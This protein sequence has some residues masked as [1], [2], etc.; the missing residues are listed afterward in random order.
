MKEH[1]ATAN[2]GLKSTG[3]ST[4]SFSLRTLCL[5][6]CILAM[7]MG[8]LSIPYLQASIRTVIDEGKNSHSIP[9]VEPSAAGLERSAS[10]ELSDSE[11]ASHSQTFSRSNTSVI[12]ESSN[13]GAD[14]TIRIEGAALSDGSILDTIP[15][16]N[17]DGGK[18]RIHDKTSSI[19]SE[20]EEEE[21]DEEEEVVVVVGP[22]EE[23]TGAEDL[24]KNFHEDRTPKAADVIKEEQALM[25]V[26][27]A[28]EEDADDR[29]SIQQETK[30]DEEEAEGSD[31]RR[32]ETVAE[33]ARAGEAGDHERISTTPRTDVIAD[34][35]IDSSESDLDRKGSSTETSRDSETDSALRQKTSDDDDSLQL[36]DRARANSSEL[37]SSRK[38]IAGLMMLAEVA[39]SVHEKMEGSRDYYARFCSCSC[40]LAMTEL[41]SCIARSL[42]HSL[43]ALP[44]TCDIFT[45]RWIPDPIGPL[46][47]HNSC[48]VLS[49]PQN[50]QANGR[51]DKL[52]E[53]YRWQPRDCDIPR[54]DP[55]AFL[56]V[57]KGKTLAFI[58]DSVARNQFESLMCVLFQ[59]A[60]PKNRGNKAMQRWYYPTHQFT[61][62]RIWSGWL[63][64]QSREPIPS[65]PDDS[66]KLTLDDLDSD[67][68]THM[69]KFDVAVISTGHWWMRKSAYI[70]D[71][72]M[73][74]G[75]G[76]KVNA[77]LNKK[78]KIEQAQAFGIAMET[79]LKKIL[80][81]PDY[82]GLTIL[83]TYSPDHYEGGRW[84]T[85]GSCTGK[86][87]PLRQDQRPDNAFN[88][89]MRSK[90]MA[91][92]RSA[93][94]DGSSSISS[95]ALLDIFEAFNLRAD[96]HPGPY[97]SPDPNKKTQRDEQGR[98]PPQDCLHWCMPG[99]VD[100]MNQLL[101]E[102]IK[103]ELRKD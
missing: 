63:V 101:L 6:G 78:K 66:V 80:A 56:E 95:L 81:I 19:N 92:L 100:T 25:V 15:S 85:G 30:P 50:C 44:D 94:R 77:T 87:Q 27:K 34:G 70:L 16:K 3:L 57:M 60:E 29:N 83:R 49:Q 10:N 45:G 98:P 23:L 76:W 31:N 1:M 18:S 9:S 40:Q 71:G 91:A 51:P 74:G 12:V 102:V 17:S 2:F 13:D 88:Q 47:S 54:L 21:E 36:L 67:F 32:P 65:A 42:A 62:I 68:A 64:K 46:Y 39:G 43:V 73:R 58:G 41:D 103:R 96:G 72:E 99:P 69:P 35:L 38:V 14:S 11:G 7:T 61:L 24:P 86:T 20:A 93:T 4:C 55:L 22:K 53:F 59:V 5:M 97:R 37:N 52:Y 48:R 79:V 82:R 89:L 26:T 84:D 28:A 8:L 33:K 75:Y 90:Q